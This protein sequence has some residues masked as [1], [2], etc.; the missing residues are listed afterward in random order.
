MDGSTNNSCDNN[1]KCRCKGNFGGIKCNDCAVGHFNFPK[2]EQCKCHWRGSTGVSCDHSGN[3]L[4]QDRYEGQKC[5]Q[6]KEGYYNF[7]YCEGKLIE[8]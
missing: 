4:C 2:C 5:E 1:G 7:P 6:C 3:C 8:K